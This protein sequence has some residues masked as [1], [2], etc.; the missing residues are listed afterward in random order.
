M[1]REE[2]MTKPLHEVWDWFEGIHYHYY[3]HPSFTQAELEAQKRAEDSTRAML[4]EVLLERCKKV[5][6][7]DEAK[8]CFTDIWATQSK[9][10][11]STI[12]GTQRVDSVDTL[13]DMGAAYNFWAW[14]L[15]QR[16]KSAAGGEPQ[17]P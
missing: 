1:T 12:I 6:D 10:A 7:A 16:A 2:A 3:P 17:Q 5:Y 11:Y 15:E 13:R 4:R 9:F 14:E 8:D